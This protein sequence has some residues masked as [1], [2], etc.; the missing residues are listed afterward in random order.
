M[1]SQEAWMNVFRPWNLVF[2]VIVWEAAVGRRLMNPLLTPAS[3]EDSYFPHLTIPHLAPSQNHPIHCSE[4]KKHAL[5]YGM[6]F[7]FL[8]LE[9]LREMANNKCMMG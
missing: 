6:I 5:N 1:L 9:S 8:Q 3:H 7:G 4:T 2:L